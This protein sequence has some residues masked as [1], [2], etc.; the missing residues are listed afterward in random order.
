M[1]TILDTLLLSPGKCDTSSQTPN[2]INPVTSKKIPVG[3]PQINVGTIMPANITAAII[4]EVSIPI[5]Y[6]G[7]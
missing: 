5:P 7:G 6:A 3:P 2:R 1:V 4:L